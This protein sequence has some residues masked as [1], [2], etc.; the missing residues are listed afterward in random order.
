MPNL[1]LYLLS[2][3]YPTAIKHRPNPPLSRRRRNRIPYHQAR[4]DNRR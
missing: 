4:A 1:K 2:A 3:P